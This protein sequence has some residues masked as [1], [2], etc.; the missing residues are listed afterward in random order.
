MDLL[1]ELDVGD[2]LLVVGD[3][4]LVLDTRKG[5]AVFK[6]EVDVLLEGF[7]ASHPHFGEVMS[8]TGSVVGR[9]VVGREEAGQCCLGGDAICWE[10]VEPQEWCLAH[11]KGEVSRHVIFVALEGKCCDVI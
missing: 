1:E 4:I 3:D 8:V 10:I 5:V 6:V 9:L 11:H 7:V 2:S